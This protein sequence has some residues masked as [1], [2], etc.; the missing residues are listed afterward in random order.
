MDSLF[1]PLLLLVSS[2]YCYATYVP[3]KELALGRI[4]RERIEKDSA[5]PCAYSIIAQDMVRTDKWG[6]LQE[7]MQSGQVWN[8][9][10]KCA[11]I[12]VTDFLLNTAQKSASQTCCSYH[13]SD[14]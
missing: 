10:F 2:A 11:L 6:A 7:T 1:G 12:A 8:V 13:L 9:S 3:L 14:K 4:D 5:I